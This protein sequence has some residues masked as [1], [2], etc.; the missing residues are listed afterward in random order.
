MKTGT[1]LLCVVLAT[2]L[3]PAMAYADEHCTQELGEP[4][5]YGGETFEHGEVS[6][7]DQIVQFEEGTGSGFE[8]QALDAL[9]EPDSQGVQLGEADSRQTEPAILTVLFRDNRLTDVSGED[10]Y[11]F[12]MNPDADPVRV[13]ISADGDTFYD[14]GRI[15]GADGAIDIAN[16][17]APIDESYRY[18][19]L[20]YDL[21]TRVGNEDPIPPQIDAV[22]AIGSCDLL[23][24]TDSDGDGTFD[25]SD[26]CPFDTTEDGSGANPTGQNCSWPVGA[27]EDEPVECDCSTTGARPSA[28]FLFFVACLGLMVLRRRQA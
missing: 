10:L 19:R 26:S 12:Q 20:R 2:L 5:I 14:I 8:S 24:E 13:E 22:G 3:L 9:D 4:T 6:F 27:V 7:A 28:G 17:D 16:S 15:Q 21:S 25:A 1:R 18:V 11:I 23:P